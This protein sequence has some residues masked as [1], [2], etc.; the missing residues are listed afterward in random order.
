M[1]ER[2]RSRRNEVNAEWTPPNIPRKLHPRAS[3]DQ[4]VFEAEKALPKRKA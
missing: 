3:S 1:D 4:R 2:G